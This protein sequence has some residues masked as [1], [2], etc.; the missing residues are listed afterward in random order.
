M[1]YYE[2]MVDENANRISALQNELRNNLAQEILGSKKLFKKCGELSRKLENLE[3]ESSENWPAR[4]KIERTG[5]AQVF[6]VDNERRELI[7]EKDFR[8]VDELTGSDFY[9]FYKPDME[10]NDIEIIY[11]DPEGRRQKVS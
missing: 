8:S 5:L 1:E 9:H 10:S 3:K 2:N 7:D 11:T 6:A 4:E